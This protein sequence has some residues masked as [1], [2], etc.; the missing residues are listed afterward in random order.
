MKEDAAKN[1][2]GTRRRYESDSIQCAA[3]ALSK[4]INTT[5]ADL[6]GCR[7]TSVDMDGASSLDSSWLT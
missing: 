6:T 1:K 5:G 2:A 4:T 7:M 3:E